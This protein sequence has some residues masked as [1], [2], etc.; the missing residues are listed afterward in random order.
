MPATH[1]GETVL[2]GL[3]NKNGEKTS[4]YLM[5]INTKHNL[6]TLSGSQNLLH[7]SKTDGFSI[8]QLQSRFLLRSINIYVMGLA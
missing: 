7:P 3:P 5:Y 8:F 6:V 2:K 4:G 1:T